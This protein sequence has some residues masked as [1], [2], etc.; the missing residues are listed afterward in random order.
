MLGLEAFLFFGVALE[1][2]II[3]FIIFNWLL[4]IQALCVEHLIALPAS[5]LNF[6]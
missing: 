5:Q 3:F 6:V 1:P 2:A 4:A